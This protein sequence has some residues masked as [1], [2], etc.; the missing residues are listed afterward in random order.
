MDATVIMIITRLLH[1]IVDILAQRLPRSEQV[2]IQEV[3]HDLGR[4]TKADI[5]FKGYGIFRIQL[6]SLDLVKVRL[7]THGNQFFLSSNFLLGF[8]SSRTSS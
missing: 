7:S 5:Q 2:T 4:A 6:A 1:R 8:S 3:K